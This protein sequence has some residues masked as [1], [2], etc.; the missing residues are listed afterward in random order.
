[1]SIVYAKNPQILDAAII[2]A[3]NV[4]GGLVIVNKSKQVYALEDQIIQLSKQINVLAKR[5]L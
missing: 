4:K 3:R 2:T 5:K 1:M